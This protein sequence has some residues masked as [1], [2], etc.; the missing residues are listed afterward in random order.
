MPQSALFGLAGVAGASAAQF[1]G[2]LADRGHLRIATGGGL[3][4]L[5]LSWV[6]LALGAHSLLALIAGIVVLDLGVQGLHISNQAAIYSLHPEARSRMTTAYMVAYFLGGVI[7]SA[8]T[9][10]LYAAHGWHTVCLLGTATALVAAIAWAITT[11][12]RR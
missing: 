1:S 11:V 7:L 3:V 2:R 6:L 4:A 8:L 5:L 10:V 9:S 12:R